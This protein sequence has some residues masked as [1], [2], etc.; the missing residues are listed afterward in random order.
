MSQIIKRL[1]RFFIFSTIC[2]LLLTP[3][4]TFLEATQEKIFIL[5]IKGVIDLGLSGFVKR[6]V[7]E[8][9]KEN[10]SLVIVEIDTFGGRLDAV[11]EIVKS[12][13]ELK[14]IPT[15]AFISAEAWSAGALI[16]LACEEIYMSPGS[17]IGSAEPRAIGMGVEEEVKDEKTISALRAKFKATAEANKHNPKLAEAFVDKDVEL[18]FVSIENKNYIL[19]SEEIEEK[20]KELG[21]EKIK[22]IKTITEKGKLL[23]L[24]AEEAKELGL[25]KEIVSNRKSLLTLLN[26]EKEEIFEP[27]PTWSE[28]LVRFLTHPIVSSLLLTLGFLGIIFEIKIPGWGLAGTLG[29]I[30]LALFFWGHYLVGLAN[31]TEILLFTLA[32]ILIFLEIFVIPGF[33]IA[34]ISGGI[35]LL[36]SIFLALIKHPLHTPKIELLQAFQVVVYSFFATLVIILLSINLFPK[37]GLWRKII[38]QERETQEGGYTTIDLTQENLI[39]KIGKTITPLRPTGK[40]DFSGK[41]FDV[42]AEGEFV[43]KDKEI[44]VVSV[45][46]NRIIVKLKEDA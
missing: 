15:K 33:G 11:G 28:N 14:P 2:Y 16:S 19:T 7:K 8:A 36:V 30:S 41:I 13:E 3:L 6:V 38:L 5:P 9:K 20:R 29:V 42:I 18:K 23:N 43:E 22:V 45:E 25:A 4:I 31:W 46:G 24:T 32:V 27:K 26:L 1:H 40:A 34:G 10:V 21:E 35:L 39:G 37:T 44:E 17:S 12:L